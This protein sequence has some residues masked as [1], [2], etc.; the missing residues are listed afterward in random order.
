MSAN[1]PMYRR[2]GFNRLPGRGLVLPLLLIVVWEIIFRAKIANPV[3][4]PS[5]GA[6]VAQGERLISSGDLWVGLQASMARY[7]AGLA[8]G[9]LLGVGIGLALGMSRLAERM[10]LPTF[11]A[12]KQ[13]S[14][15][16][17][18][19]LLS[20]GFGLRE[21]AKIAFIVF[22]CVFPILI[23]TYEGVRSVSIDYLEV[24]RAYRFNLPQLLGKIVL[25]A[26][27][28]A[29]FRGLH[30]GVFFSWLGTVG[31]EYFFVAGAGVGNIIIDGRNS[32]QMDLVL[33]GV[34]VVGLIG[35]LLNQII[36]MVE[37]RALHWLHPANP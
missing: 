32:S 18:I 2:F 6:V 15:F 9:G 3:F 5:V 33:F 13:V 8:I 21:P 25:P 27:S 11:D 35:Y 28:P 17:L 30:L 16:A 7:F 37:R 19:P 22:T 26:A 24:G 10:F 12:L 36:T 31:A 4:L 20:F 23:N 29:I 34:F 14:P 1:T